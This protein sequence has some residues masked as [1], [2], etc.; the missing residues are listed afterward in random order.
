[1]TLFLIFQATKSRLNDLQLLFKNRCENRETMCRRNN[2]QK[3]VL[4][5]SGQHYRILLTPRLL[6]WPI[7]MTTAS[8]WRSC[9]LGITFKGVVV[10]RRKRVIIGP[11]FRQQC[12]EREQRFFPAMTLFLKYTL[13]DFQKPIWASCHHSVCLEEMQT[14]YCLKQIY[15]CFAYFGC[16]F[17]GP[18]HELAP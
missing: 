4:H 16:S 12:K 18:K 5:L 10:L 1:M 11:I 13:T 3:I 15:N 6:C 7:V 2:V 9:F 8:L 14:T 17:L